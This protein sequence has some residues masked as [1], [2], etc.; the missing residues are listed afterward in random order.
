[1]LCDADNDGIN[2]TMV[3]EYLNCY[4]YESEA[5]IPVYDDVKVD[6]TILNPEGNVIKTLSKTFPYNDNS[7]ISTKI[8]ELPE[9]GNQFL[10]YKLRFF[11]IRQRHIVY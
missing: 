1:M 8:I 5:D 2:E 6:I 9:H 7:V 3:Y 4:I 11:D 10:K